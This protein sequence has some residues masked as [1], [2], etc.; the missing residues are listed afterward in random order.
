MI[1]IR[2]Y[3]ECLE[4]ALHY[5]K[6]MVERA[7]ARC[8]QKAE[9]RLVRKIGRACSAV[10]SSCLSAIGSLAVPDLLL[11]AV[12]REREYPLVLFEFSEAVTT[13]DH[14]LQRIYGGF[15]AFLADIF[16]VKVSG[17]KHSQNEFGGASY[18]P[19]ST[20][21]ILSEELKYRGYIYAEWDTD[22]SG[23]NLARDKHYL[24]CPPSD[25]LVSDIVESAVNSLAVS[26]KQWFKRAVEQ[27]GKKES[28][29]RYLTR[30][31]SAS[32]ADSLLQE[33]DARQ[34]RNSNVRSRFWVE[35]DYVA[36][37]INRLSHSMDPDRGILIFMS[38]IFSR[39][40]KIFG[41]YALQRARTTGMK[42]PIENFAELNR[43]LKFA[44][45]HDKAPD[46]FAGAVASLT[47][48]AGRMDATVNFDEIFAAHSE[49]IRGNKVMATLAW[50]LDGM[51]LGHN[52]PLLFWDKKKFL[53]SGRDFYSALKSTCGF[54]PH[55]PPVQLQ[56]VGDSANEDEV[57]YS[58]VHDALR[59]SGFQVVSVSY[60]GAQGGTPILPDPGKGKAQP[61]EYVDAM[62]ALDG[63]VLLNESKE[64]FGGGVLTDCQRLADYK[65][66]GRKQEALRK[67]LLK[68][69][70]LHSDG[71]LRTIWV[72]VSFSA[73]D[74]SIKWK[75]CIIDFMFILLGRA[76]WKIGM[77]SDSLSKHIN[78][79][80]GKASLPRIFEACPSS[81]SKEGHAGGDSA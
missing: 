7:L 20:P 48:R 78:S 14:E 62:A 79:L 41:V 37:K 12:V 8:P 30:V 31:N 50:F 45:A 24:S 5:M 68:L 80:Q 18:D 27:C 22:K 65:T 3:Y 6:P 55:Y 74:E 16:Y 2:I 38:M 34:Q 54:S 9:I 53:S 36:A 29:C 67:T 52:G 21:R 26:D 81:S 46:W 39:T 43:R 56:D 66:D 44:L 72:G 60:P 10:G 1:E 59:P 4:Q 61:R 25:D 75:P 64:N 63:D 28:Y 32:G 57:T 77:F 13:E 23:E 70:C 40:R 58:L 69:G 19:Y 17:K 73:R 51:Y 71:K 11:T 33:W 49:Q 35:K 15:A 47:G 42:A 76:E